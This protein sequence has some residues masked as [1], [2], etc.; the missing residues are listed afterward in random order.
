M[1][2]ELL[3]FKVELLLR[4]AFLI[5]MRIRYK[6]NID[7]YNMISAREHEIDHILKD[8]KVKGFF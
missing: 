6:N 3:N 7:F 2:Y 5:K 8:E 4:K 1:D